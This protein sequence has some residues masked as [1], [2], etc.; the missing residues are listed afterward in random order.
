MSAY[1]K[2]DVAQVLQL[3]DVDTQSGR[4][5]W[6]PRGNKKFDSNHVGREA[7]FVR[8]DGYVQVR[9][10]GK[11]YYRHRILRAV[12]NGE[13]LAMEVDHIN[14][15]P[16]DDRAVNLRDVSRDDQ[17]RNLRTPT[18][19]TSGRIGVS[20]YRKN[21]W[22]AAIWRGNKIVSL[23]QF[24]DFDAACAARIAAEIAYGYHPN[25]GRIS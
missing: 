23:G 7:G 14:G 10:C 3:L 18:T 15:V 8:R 11:L 16:G 1:A 21:R 6:K 13:D 22:Q 19:N 25:H 4:M 12:A 20:R 17:Q 9:I 5:F 24:D 2:I